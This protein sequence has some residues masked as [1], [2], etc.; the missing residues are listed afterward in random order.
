[1]VAFDLDRAGAACYRGAVALA[2]ALEELL[3]E[4]VERGELFHFDHLELVDEV[5]EMLEAGVEVS[6]C[7]EQ[8]H[9]LKVGVVDVRVDSKKSLEDHSDDVHEVAGEGH[10]ERAREHF[11]VVELR[12]H[13]GH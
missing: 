4:L 1:M 6:L 3:D 7:A 10:S 2:L 5:D 12:L 9:V 13:P 11:F 8:H